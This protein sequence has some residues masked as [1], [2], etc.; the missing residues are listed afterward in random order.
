MEEWLERYPPPAAEERVEAHEFSEQERRRLRRMT[1]QRTIDLH[2]LLRAEALK[3]TD[4]FLRSAHKSGI[5]KV[6]IIH[7]KGLHSSVEPVLRKEIQRLLERL[8]FTGEF[9]HP[10][11][12]LGGSGA[13][14]VILR[15]R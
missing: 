13:T 10:K 1:P 7:G 3:Q 14:W 6:L 4:A 11:R 9:G 2:G 8:P 5:R 12:E 15:K